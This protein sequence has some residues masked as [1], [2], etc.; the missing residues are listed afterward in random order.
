MQILLHP[1]LIP[2]QMQTFKQ[3]HHETHNATLNGDSQPSYMP[4]PLPRQYVRPAVEEAFFLLSS[5]SGFR[6]LHLQLQDQ[7]THRIRF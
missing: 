3:L 5:C 1:S 4:I 7:R 2:H 6:N